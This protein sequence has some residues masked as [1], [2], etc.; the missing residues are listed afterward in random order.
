MRTARTRIDS[1]VPFTSETAKNT[2]HLIGTHSNEI[3]AA[4]VLFEISRTSGKI[5]LLNPARIL[6]C[7]KL[8]PK[9]RLIQNIK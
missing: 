7:G 6:N 3:D 4:Q 8:W 1:G 5:S 9:H 2:L